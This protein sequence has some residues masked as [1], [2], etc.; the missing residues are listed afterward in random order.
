[1][2]NES[3]FNDIRLL[4]LGLLCASYQM[5]ETNDE[6]DRA[7]DILKKRTVA[8]TASAVRVPTQQEVPP[9]PIQEGV[10]TIP[11]QQM[12]TTGNGYRHEG[13]SSVRFSMDADTKEVLTAIAATR[14]A[15]R[16]SIY[17]AVSDVSFGFEDGDDFDDEH[18]ARD[19]M[20]MS[21][22][23]GHRGAHVTGDG[24]DEYYG[25]EQQ[26]D[27]DYLEANY[28]KNNRSANQRRES[29]FSH[30]TMA[31]AGTTGTAGTSGTMGTIQTVQMMEKRDSVMSSFSQF[32]FTDD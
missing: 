13:R 11:I 8:V 22:A 18:G 10:P 28:R 26:N 29:T 1:M 25:D 14:S 31:T 2:A 5:D 3:T 4:P 19:D 32:T 15:H 20:S 24:D 6:E 12:S 7:T 21:K 16:S 23:S 27:N 9:Q 17:S 30:G